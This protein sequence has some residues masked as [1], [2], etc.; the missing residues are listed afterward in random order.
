MTTKKMIIAALACLTLLSSNQIF[1]QAE[2]SSLAEKASIMTTKMDETLDLDENQES[3]FYE[4]TLK[5]LTKGEELKNSDAS[6]S[7]KYKILKE[8]NEAKTKEMKELL[9]KTQFE[10]YERITE[11]MKEEMKEGMKGKGKGQRKGQR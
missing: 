2:K 1:A 9:S 10:E 6:R 3:I 5:Y 7:E 11:E 8:N 4:I